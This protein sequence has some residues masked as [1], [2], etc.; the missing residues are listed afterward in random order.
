MSVCFKFRLRRSSHR[1]NVLTW[2]PKLFGA[3]A[4][5]KRQWRPAG[6]QDLGQ[7]S[8]RRIAWLWR[9]HRSLDRQR[10]TFFEAS[11]TRWTNDLLQLNE[12]SGNHGSKQQPNDV[13]RRNGGRLVTQNLTS[14]R[15]SCGAR[16]LPPS[17]WAD[18]RWLERQWHTTSASYAKWHPRRRFRGRLDMFQ[19][20]LYQTFLL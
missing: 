3:S 6:W 11:S 18:Y 14:W 1:S 17:T 7:S 20:F 16:F 2:K 10:P 12:N 13:Q 5:K 19:T 4:G 9:W 15:S 8:R